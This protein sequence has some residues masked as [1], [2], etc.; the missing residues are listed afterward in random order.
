M[1]IAIET[2]KIFESVWCDSFHH[3]NNYV[4]SF[5]LKPYAC[6]LRDNKMVERRQRNSIMRTISEMQPIYDGEWQSTCAR[7][8]VKAFEHFATEIIV[9]V[10]WFI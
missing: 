1:V 8:E 7:F 9:H 3:P 5:Q 6:I 4:K 10:N 2:I